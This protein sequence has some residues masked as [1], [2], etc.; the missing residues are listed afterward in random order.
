MPDFAQKIKNLDKKYFKNRFSL[1]KNRTIRSGGFNLEES[2]AVVFFEIV[3]L[4]S[5]AY[6]NDMAYEMQFFA[7][8][9][10]T[11]FFLEIGK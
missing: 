3:R 2:I 7:H 6:A 10:T 4:H 5:Q 8:I 11:S 9:S 1:I